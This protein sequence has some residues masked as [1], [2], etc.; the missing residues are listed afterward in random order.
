MGRGGGGGTGR[1]EG[2]ARAGWLGRLGNCS[3]SRQPLSQPFFLW[4]WTT[5]F[6]DFI[7][8]VQNAIPK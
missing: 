7:Q 3:H 5:G 4:Q 2:A 1:V 8:Y 6:Y